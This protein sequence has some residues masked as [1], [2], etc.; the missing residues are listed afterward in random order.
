M[1][2]VSKLKKSFTLR[3]NPP[4][5][6]STVRG[7]FRPLRSE[8]QAVNGLTFS[9]AKGERVAF[10]GPNGAGKSTTIKMLS[11][12]LYPTS[13]DIRV[14]GL[15]PW[16]QR[17]K[18]AFRIG[19]VFGQKSQ[20]WYHLPAINTFRLL[21]KI[22]EIEAAEFER[23]LAELVEAFAIGPFLHQTVRKLSL[24]QRMRC[25]L[26]ASL[27]HKPEVL[28][29]DEPTIGLDVTAKAVIRDLIKKMSEKEGTTILLTSHDTVDMEA[30]CD[31]VLVINQGDLLLD[32]PVRRLRRSFLQRKLITI[33]S[34]E[35]DWD[36][37]IPGV[38][39]LG[40]EP[41]QKRLAFN[42]QETSV[43]KVIQEALKRTRLRDITVEDPPMEEI[44]HRIYS[45]ERSGRR[46]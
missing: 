22:Y 45:Q 29:L 38:E 31:R 32:E 13:G 43:E 41:H 18:L 15:T 24:G 35:A 26:V 6:F 37:S 4:G 25:E 27:L 14:A 9:I 17:G 3:Q 12:I 1:I 36:S 23:R 10:I 42:A 11:G 44:I 16:K 46:P 30:V 7:I 28:F 33:F 21:G 8:V 34:E 40:S 39:V 19:T 2:E 20:L 5:A